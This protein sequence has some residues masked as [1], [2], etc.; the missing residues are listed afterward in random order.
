MENTGRYRNEVTD[1]GDDLDC[2]YLMMIKMGA[3]HCFND[4][5]EKAS[6]Y[7]NSQEVISLW[8]VIMTFL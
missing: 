5:K 8:A 2:F 7:H 4:N 1:F 3:P 6:D